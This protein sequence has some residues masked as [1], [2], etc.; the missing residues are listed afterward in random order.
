V[1]AHV[2]EL[3]GMANFRARIREMYRL[4]MPLGSS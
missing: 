2:P 3:W 4:R 1:T